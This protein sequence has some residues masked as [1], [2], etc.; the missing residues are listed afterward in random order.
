M[1][2]KKR[3]DAVRTEMR[4]GGFSV[5]ALS[6][7][8]DMQYLTGFQCSVGTLFITPDDCMLLTD[9]RYVR[10]ARSVNPDINAIDSA[11]QTYPDAFYHNLESSYSNPVFGY[12]DNISLAL[13]KTFQNA[14]QKAQWKP[15]GHLMQRVRSVKDE[16]ELKMLEKACRVTENAF[17]HI[18]TFIKPGMTEV[19]VAIEIERHMK[20]NG[21]DQPMS[22]DIIVASGIRSTYSHGRASNKII[23]KD[24]I[25]LMDFGCKYNEYCSDLTRTI[26]MGH[27]SDEQKKVYNLVKEAQ[28]NCLAAL[29]DGTTSFELHDILR[30]TC[31]PGG[32]DKYCG[33]GVGHAI[34]LSLHE[35]PFLTD[36]GYP[37]DCVTLH[38][39][40]VVT[41][42]PTIYLVP[43]NFGVRIEDMVVVTD[44]GYRNL[45]T[46][47]KELTEL[48]F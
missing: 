11:K 4:K 22:Y 24:D 8:S 47:D 30:R 7:V 31:A 10:H 20:Q 41:I 3:I 33:N 38:T 18:L 29:R 43:S 34:G 45:Y 15:F 46:I 13:F 1:D 16:N 2:Y 21:A 14:A 28:V 42:E 39:N 36:T 35:H 27:A 19:E 26:F 40:N 12:D 17:S 9:Y 32:Y 5:L 23:E 6:S 48:G 37:A 25:V 44:T